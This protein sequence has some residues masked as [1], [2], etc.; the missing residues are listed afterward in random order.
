M[1]LL[2]S[3]DWPGNVRQLRNIIE[4]GINNCN[5]NILEV[6]DLS[7]EISEGLLNKQIDSDHIAK[8]LIG[9][10]LAKKISQRIEDKNRFQNFCKNIMEIKP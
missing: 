10:D 6:N 3:Y 9:I 1:G 2:T 7:S 5:S 8:D 4:R